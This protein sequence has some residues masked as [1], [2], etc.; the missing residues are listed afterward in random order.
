MW[1]KKAVVSWAVFGT[2]SPNC[3]L[4]LCQQ[5]FRLHRGLRRDHRLRAL[6]YSIRRSLGTQP[7]LRSLPFKYRGNSSSC[8]PEGKFQP[9]PLWICAAPVTASHEGCQ[10]VN[11]IGSINIIATPWTSRLPLGHVGSAN[12]SPL[13]SRGPEARPTT[14]YAYRD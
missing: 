1:Q 13:S 2:N 10:V 12:Y 9:V 8:P 11:N 5:F 3:D 7:S 6:I 14:I 4:A